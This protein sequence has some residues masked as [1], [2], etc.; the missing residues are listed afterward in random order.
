MAHCTADE[1]SK[2]VRIL[3]T[4]IIYHT[5][6]DGHL[7]GAIL[8][9]HLADRNPIMVRRNYD[10]EFD[11]SLIDKDTEVWM[12]D[13]SLQPWTEM[14][15]LQQEAGKLIWIDHHKSA[16][17][18]YDEWVEAEGSPI[19]G[20]RQDGIAACRLCWEYCNPGVPLPRAVFLADRYDVWQWQDVPGAIEYQYGT[21]F[22]ETDPATRD[23]QDFWFQQ[24]NPIKADSLVKQVEEEGKL[25]MRYKERSN[26]SYMSD[27]CFETEIDGLKVVA[28]NRKGN[29]QQFDSVFNPEKHH[30]M[31]TFAWAKGM[32]TVSLY[33]SRKDVDVSAV[34]KKHGGGG[35]AGAAGFQCQEL[36]FELK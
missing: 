12:A 1:S 22:Y 31:L 30:A 14:I 13:L 15:R 5:D 26:S 24:L 21:K 9:E 19:D 25:L 4:V 16:I 6:I 3:K 18:Y 32:W 36:P 35:H 8:H 7:S 28:V 17:A 29:S 11:W 2:G 23:G 20:R 34:A 27:N 33:T 10:D